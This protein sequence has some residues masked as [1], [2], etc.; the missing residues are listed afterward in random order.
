MRQLAT[1]TLSNQD[2]HAALLVHTYT[3][4][5]DRAILIRVV[6]D[7]IQNAG[8]DYYCYITIREAGAGSYYEMQPRTKATILAGI[9]S[10]GFSSIILPVN[11]TDVVRVY[12]L[13][14]AGDTTTPDITTRIYELTYL[15]PTTA[16]QDRVDVT[17]TGEVAIDLDNIKQATNP[18]T[19]TNI[20]VPVVTNVTS[21][22][23]PV[24]LDAGTA[25]IAGMLQ[26]MADDNNGATFD[27]GT[28]SL[29]RIQAK[30]NNLP[31]NPAAVGSP[32]TLATDAVN[33]AA[34]ATDAVNEIAAAV[35]AG[36]AGDVW[37]EDM[38][39]HDLPNSFGR[40]VHFIHARP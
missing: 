8:G 1:S 3:A 24:A 11:N 27:A 31:A 37:D 7:Q 39:G 28:D 6:V 15:R 4:D 21:I 20:T 2:I 29:E 30:V 13:G 26:K 25:T 22:G 33:A 23:T 5:A 38:A 16:G 9:T 10:I 32:M 36:V 40:R 35:G 34:L 17:A 14:L 19:L 12:V 18:T